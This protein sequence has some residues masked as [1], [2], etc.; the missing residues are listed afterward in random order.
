MKELETFF[1]Y[2]GYKN[3]LRENKILI[4]TDV[5]TFFKVGIL[6]FKFCFQALK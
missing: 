6:G 4:L 3:M 1:V 5:N 2:F